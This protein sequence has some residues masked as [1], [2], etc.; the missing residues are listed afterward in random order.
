MNQVDGLDSKEL[1][2][3]LAI[4]VHHQLQL[5]PPL[6]ERRVPLTPPGQRND[7]I[8]RGSDAR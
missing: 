3:D 1:T 5:A 2:L 6:H 4:H 8:L 7:S